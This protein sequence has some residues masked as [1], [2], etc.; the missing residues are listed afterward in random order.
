VPVS[1]QEDLREGRGRALV[2]AN[3]W[4]ILDEAKR[5]V[6]ACVFQVR[7]IPGIEQKLGGN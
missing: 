6:A 3:P 2:P 4:V 7:S 5:S 1:A